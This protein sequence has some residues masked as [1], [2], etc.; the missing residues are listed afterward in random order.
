MIYIVDYG[1]GNLA[2]IRN[3]LGR[4]GFE[5][6]ISGDPAEIAAATKIILPGIGAFDEGMRN[7]KTRGL[8]KLLCDTAATRRVP[9]LGICLGMQLLGRGS[10][11]GVEPG[12]GL[13]DMHFKRFEPNDE[14]GLKSL[15]MGWNHVINTAGCTLLAAYEKTP[16]FYFVHRYYAVCRESEDIWGTTEYGFPFASVVGRGLICGVQFHPE[17]SHNFGMRLLRNFAEGP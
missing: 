1:V 7:L 16:R 6:E 3:M 14:R 2:A 15:H 5:S 10:D 4:M 12:L 17:K 11:E 9:L 8:V 13:I